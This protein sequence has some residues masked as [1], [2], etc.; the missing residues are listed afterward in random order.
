MRSKKARL[1]PSL[2][3][4]VLLSIVVSSCVEIPS[5][6][7][8]PV[9]VEIDTGRE[10]KELMEDT[11]DELEEAE[12][13]A[14]EEFRE[15]IEDAID[16][17]LAYTKEVDEIFGARLD[18][19]IASLD[20][21]V[22]SKLIWIQGYTQQVRGY[23][24]EIIQATGDEA[25]RTIEE[26]TEGMRRTI[27]YA[28]LAAQRTTI[29]A[30]QNMVYLV[31]TIADRSVAIGG[32][33]AGLL[34]TFICA[35]G[36][37]RLIYARNVPARGAQ[38]GLALGFM[39]LSLLFSFLPFSA[40][41]P[42]VRAR[43]L[44]QTGK[45]TAFE[46]TERLPAEQPVIFRFFPDPLVVPAVAP[47]PPSLAVEGIHLMAFGKPTV[48]FG[49]ANLELLG[50]HNDKLEVDIGP[51]IDDPSLARSVEVQFGSGP[52][53]IRGA[54][55]VRTAT[56]ESTEIPWFSM[57]DVSGR[58]VDEA[59]GELE[60]LGLRVEDARPSEPHQ[61]IEVG[62]VTRSRPEANTW[63]EWGSM[64]TLY[65]SSGKPSVT[66]PE[67][68]NRT[69]D[70]ARASLSAKG[71]RVGPV[72]ERA[73]EKI[74]KGD[75]IRSDPPTGTEVEWG[76]EVTLYVSQG[77][78]PEIHPRSMFFVRYDRLSS[79][80]FD[81]DPDDGVERIRYNTGLNDDDF[82]CGITGFMVQGVLPDPSRHKVKGDVAALDVYMEA[83]RV[84]GDWWI[85]AS[86]ETRDRPKGDRYQSW[87]IDTL[88]VSNKVLD[89][90]GAEFVR[91]K[92][93]L[94]GADIRRLEF[95]PETN[96]YVGDTGVSGEDY[97]CGVVGFSFQDA[98]YTPNPPYVFRTLAIDEETWVVHARFQDLSLPI[99]D[100][101]AWTRVNVL[102]LKKSSDVDIRFFP[103]SL[104][105][106]ITGEYWRTID[107]T[108]KDYRCG[109]F[110]VSA[111]GGRLGTSGRYGNIVL[112]R[113]IDSGDGPWAAWAE[114]P[115]AGE[116]YRE[117]WI[118]DLFCLSREYLA[119][120]VVYD[121]A[122]GSCNLR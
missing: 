32:G 79:E 111:E 88:C 46:F 78:P 12:R 68:E 93:G 15:T 10:L 95:E 103:V 121:C 117:D 47:T 21:A 29:V 35:Y 37:G 59:Q 113:V 69:L 92:T 64:V 90:G 39:A 42:I 31:D 80:H 72:I 104:P 30:T 17:L 16:S 22:Q 33:I 5:G 83:D 56:P 119:A 91:F 65:V 57:P 8:V 106:D 50:Y 23:A 67:V 86:F 70:E 6:E 75:V 53:A 18:R 114:F 48:T 34:L 28:E 97:R 73:D 118:L 9:D 2:L 94:A 87:N 76:S 27:N 66:V 100:Q 44:A 45:G 77:K 102:C 107:L 11:L 110:G 40:L 26:A 19:M 61:K 41:V 81:D 51:V 4:V 3:R 49:S 82:K 1:I 116:E 20:A 54:V 98:I 43:A 112:A 74:D 101:A 13:I 25:R 14:G 85:N 120:D 36:W 52:E 109:V 96:E 38:R 62:L 71:L 108:G 99:R 122:D 55:P 115:S 63:V 105:D 84:T 58:T 89:Q 24:L 60:A 7:P